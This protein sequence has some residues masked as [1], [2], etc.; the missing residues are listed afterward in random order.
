MG[1]FLSTPA[2]LERATV[3]VDGILSLT[4]VAPTTRVLDLCCGVGRHALEL[5]RRGFSVTGVDSTANFL[6]QAR[7]KAQEEG[8][9]VEFIHQDMREFRRP[10]SFDLALNLNTSFGYF[11]DAAD[12][13][14][15]LRNIHASLQPGG[16]FVL[17]TIGK[18][19]LARIFQERDWFEG[20][21]YLFLQER[22]PSEDWGRMNVRY[23]KVTSGRKE[24]WSFTHRLFAATEM[25]TLI[26]EAGFLKIKAY[27]DLQGNPYDNTARRLVVVAEK[28]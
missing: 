14:K 25:V 19:V 26:R 24:E 10:G 16:S 6:D 9:V 21:G 2:S 3:E 27:G 23:I 20:D 7:R 18:E 15:V 17:E 8:L 1:P 13:L 11:E 28:D 12:D 5:A 22:H 4:S